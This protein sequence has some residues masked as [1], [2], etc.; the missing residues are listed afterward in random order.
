[1]KPGDHSEAGGALCRFSPMTDC[2]IDCGVVWSECEEPEPCG[3]FGYH[4]PSCPAAV[5]EAD[6]ACF[7][8][9]GGSCFVCGV[10]LDPRADLDESES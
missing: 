4:F 2:C 5:R 6:H 9:G 7:D 1:M 10:A 3:G 8:A